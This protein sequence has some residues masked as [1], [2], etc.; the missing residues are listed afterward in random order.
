MPQP[1]GNPLDLE[2]PDAQIWAETEA[3]CRADPKFE[4]HAQ[5]AERFDAAARAAA[6]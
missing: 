1:H 2:K 5:W 3:T 4:P 6:E